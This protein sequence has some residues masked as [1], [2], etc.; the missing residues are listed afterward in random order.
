MGSLVVALVYPQSFL[1][2]EGK[3]VLAATVEIKRIDRK[4]MN[5]DV[6]KVITDDL[7][8]NIQR[9]T[10]TAD[11]GIFDGSIELRVHDRSDVKPIMDRIKKVDGI[12]E[13]MR[14]N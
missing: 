2:T 6:A 3:I 14:I 13:V 7:D 8:I 5:F 9:F 4:G 11:E 10:V 12:Q 1:K